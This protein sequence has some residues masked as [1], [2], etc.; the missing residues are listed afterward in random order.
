MTSPCGRD[1]AKQR[2]QHLESVDELHYST[3][4]PRSADAV[5][6]CQA[7]SCL[8][9]ATAEDADVLGQ[10]LPR[11]GDDDDWTNIGG[12]MDV[13]A[14]TGGAADNHYL[15][16]VTDG[17]QEPPASALDDDD[18][19]RVQDYNDDDDAAMTSSSRQR[20]SSFSSSDTLTSSSANVYRSYMHLRS[21]TSR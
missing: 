9:A 20:T 5:A 3:S 6:C 8:M 4:I 11:R 13:D 21:K 16:D 17:P 12:R 10:S 18:A 7:T 2:Q 1:D 14:P 19:T 15:H